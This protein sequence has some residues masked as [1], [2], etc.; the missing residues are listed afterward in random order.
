[1]KQL[2]YIFI[3]FS[4]FSVGFINPMKAQVSEDSELFQTLRQNDSLLF[5]DG[6]NPCNLTQFKNL[7]TADLEFYHDTSGILNS[8]EEFIKVMA[9]GICKK[10]NP[11]KSRRELVDGS[12]ELYPLYNNGKLYAAIQIGN[13]LFYEKSSDKPETFNGRAKFTHLWIL[14][15]N[16]W[17]IKRIYSF[18][19][20]DN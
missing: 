13:H 5:N 12:L 9:N 17:R 18:D 19:Q 2:S 15:S 1:M 4:L 7:T 6:F 11:Y 8:S 16:Q 20:Q 10:D 14:E 3:L